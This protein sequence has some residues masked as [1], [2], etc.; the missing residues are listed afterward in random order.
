MDRHE[1]ETALAGVASCGKRYRD[2]LIHFVY[3]NRVQ[4]LAES[5]GNFQPVSQATNT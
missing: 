3:T 1:A 5:I 4:G 2:S